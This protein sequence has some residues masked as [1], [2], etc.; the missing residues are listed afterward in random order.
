MKIT[1]LTGFKTGLGAAVAAGIITLTVPTNAQDQKAPQDKFEYVNK[2]PLAQPSIKS[3][4][5][6]WATRTFSEEVALPPPCGSA[7]DSILA[8][9]PDPWVVVQGQQKVLTFAVDVTNNILYHYDAEGN[10]IKGYRIASGKLTPEMQTDEGLR[11]VSHVE[12]YPY[13]NAPAHT[14]RHKNPRD[15]GPKC[16]ILDKLDP[17]TGKKGITGE[18]IHGN[19]DASSIGKHVSQGCM[20]MDNDVIKELAKIVKRGDLVM[21][22]R[23]IK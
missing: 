5:I 21:I 19:K 1:R 14:K 15:Y 20:R 8:F 23:R 3:K 12:T 16:I 11:M 9:A 2:T 18:F 6:R 13:K 22:I 7:A 4:M 10:P 17:S